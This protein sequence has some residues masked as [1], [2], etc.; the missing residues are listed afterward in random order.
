M[1]VTSILIQSEDSM[2]L[3]H[4]PQ[5]SEPDDDIIDLTDIVEKGA[6]PATPVEAGSGEN[7]LEAQ[8]ADLLAGS[9]K[10]PVAD[11]DEFDLDALLK[12]SGLDE[13]GDVSP[14]APAGDVSPVAAG[15]AAPAD[16]DMDMPDMG[17]V[18]ALLRD[19]VAPEQ[20]DAS[21]PAEPTE[22]TV[23]AG[24]ESAPEAPPADFEAVFQAN[25][26]AVE[27]TESEKST[28]MEKVTEVTELTASTPAAPTG[29]DEVDV[30]DLDSLLD[31]IMNP[32]TAAPA[33][34]LSSPPAS[35]EGEASPAPDASALPEEGADLA[36]LD[37]L[38]D[39]A[40]ESEGADEVARAAVDFETPPSEPAADDEFDLDALLSEARTEMMEEPSAP[41]APEAPLSAH[42]GEA[43]L[44]DLDALF[45]AGEEA[46]DEAGDDLPL[47]TDLG[48]PLLVGEATSRNDG[49]LGAA[50]LDSLNALA[51][52]IAAMQEKLNATSEAGNGPDMASFDA[53]RERV[54][55]VT[56][57]IHDMAERHASGLAAAEARI[58][59]LE[60]ELAASSAV[61][62]RL[63]DMAA[64]VHRLA[65]GHM[66]GLTSTEAR[67]AALEAELAAQ[68]A[69]SA[70]PLEFPAA[71]SP[72]R[73]ELLA[74]IRE[75][76]A[77]E[78]QEGEHVPPYAENMSEGMVR[79]E[80]RVAA[81]E[82]KGEKAAA[83]AAARVIREEIAA[84]VAEMGSGEY[85]AG[86]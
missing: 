37:A 49:D 86:E 59:D 30:D 76:V 50:V 3:S 21:A 6:V 2:D 80:D 43:P 64:E 57:E 11:E 34:P 7:P 81:V 44:G 47:E 27:V 75:V 25:M 74:L 12:A 28:E 48:N 82:M 71:D 33:A 69:R 16:E 41:S 70:A 72:F 61:G 83:E 29:E 68:R 78:L 58:S 53:L 77:R 26:T 62:I 52:D 22:G 54:E 13:E 24:A 63:D 31:S 66:G 32:D 42:E 67:I 73:A 85:P 51:A 20:P 40:R 18:D 5:S 36:D 46:A 56:A 45:E 39:A 15:H 65:E 17:E 9:G 8:M 79:L 38:L 60:A 1:F 10:V 55:D 35:A 14:Q 19:L 4:A 84:L 23:S